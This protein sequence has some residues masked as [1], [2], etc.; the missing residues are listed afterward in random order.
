MRK[1]SSLEGGEPAA[2]VMR[3]SRRREELAVGLFRIC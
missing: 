2:R 1:R 3:F